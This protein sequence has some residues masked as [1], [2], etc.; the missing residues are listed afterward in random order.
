[1]SKFL[2]FLNNKILKMTFRLSGVLLSFLVF[3]FFSKLNNI[4]N[5]YGI[6]IYI[7]SSLNMCALFGLLGHESQLIKN[8]SKKI[9]LSFL[10]SSLL[11]AI[12][13]S[14]YASSLG[15]T[16]SPLNQLLLVIVSFLFNI[17][18]ISSLQLIGF[19]ND[20][21]SVFKEYILVFS[22]IATFPLY[23]NLTILLLLLIGILFLF[24]FKFIFLN[25]DLKNFWFIKGE[26][27]ILLLVMLLSLF[28]T[29]IP[30]QVSAKLLSIEELTLLLLAIKFTSIIR[31]Y[32]NIANAYIYP[33]LSEI[34]NA[35]LITKFNLINLCFGVSLLLILILV[36][37][38]NLFD[39]QNSDFFFRLI[40]IIGLAQTLFISL[41]SK[42]TFLILHNM[43]K[44]VLK[45]QLVSFFIAVVF[46]S[47]YLIIKQPFNSV[48]LFMFISI[49]LPHIIITFLK[50]ES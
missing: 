2:F 29:Q 25:L 19:G 24:N 23:E 20:I 9:P 22:C 17:N 11:F 46:S 27:K 39:I 33:I 28:S 48:L 42:P 1:M 4:N 35:Y 45:Y 40:L 5:D 7:I 36:N 34:K 47:F 37:Q 13:W 10:L 6:I 43:S 30:I 32:M 16:S 41:S 31:V 12:V 21:I 38:F 26:S 14:F 8:Y 50:Y 44:I 18:K 49:S 15:F 3:Y